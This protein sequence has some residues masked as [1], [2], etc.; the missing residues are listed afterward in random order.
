MMERGQ[1]ATCG[2]GRLL[3][4][5]LNLGTEVLNGKYTKNQL[6]AMID[7]K[8]PF[9]LKLLEEY[10]GALTSYEKDGLFKKFMELGRQIVAGDYSEGQLRAMLKHENPFAL[11]LLEKGS[12]RWA[13]A[14]LGAERIFSARKAHKAWGIAMNHGY[15]IPYQQETLMRCA[16]EN[17]ARTANWQLIFLFDWN[18]GK[19]VDM[20]PKMH[21]SLDGALEER[22]AHAKNGWGQR[23]PVLGYHLCNLTPSFAGWSYVQRREEW[24][25][26]KIYFRVRLVELVQILAGLSYSHSVMN[27]NWRYTCEMSETAGEYQLELDQTRLLLNILGKDEC[28]EPGVM[29]MLR[30]DA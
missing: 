21:I 18:M 6:Q 22:N 25:T 17:E 13:C 5:Y 16:A 14:I 12:Y 23:K 26:D 3:E 11:K 15:R 9:T 30:W 28:S 29:L 24:H 20:L 1:V 10:R 8:N 19:A 27:T 4:M 2:A 7:H